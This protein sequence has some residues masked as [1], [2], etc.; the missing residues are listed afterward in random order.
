MLSEQD[1]KRQKLSFN[2]IPLFTKDFYVSKSDNLLCHNVKDY[3]ITLFYSPKCVFCK[4]C[5]PL[6][7][8]LCDID[9][10]IALINVSENKDLVR[11]SQTTKYPLKYVP[12]I[13]FYDNGK[14][15]IRYTG[16]RCEK[17]LRN[18][19]TD[20]IEKIVKIRSKTSTYLNSQTITSTLSQPIMYTNSI[21]PTSLSE[22][23]TTPT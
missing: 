23:A 7:E 18:F 16:P 10:Q 2:P 15:Y 1:S 17:D 6:F 9:C 14:Q 22:S 5:L 11:I 3:S 4:E 8:N 21:Q 19:I 13:L 20:V 12:L